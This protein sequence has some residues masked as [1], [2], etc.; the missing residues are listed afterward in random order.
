MLQEKRHRRF[1]QMQRRIAGGRQTA[2]HQRP[3]A[4][5]HKVAHIVHRQGRAAMR[6]QH[7]VHRAGEIGGGIDE[8]AVEVE[9]YGSGQSHELEIM[10]F[11]CF[12]TA[13]GVAPGGGTFQPPAVM[14]GLLM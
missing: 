7:M 14:A 10:H 9:Q 3:R 12:S 2:R 13:T 1:D 5:A 8:R 11:Y 6:G 4:V